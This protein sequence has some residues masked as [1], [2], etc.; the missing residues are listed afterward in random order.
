[1]AHI[2]TMYIL[3]PFLGALMRYNLMSWMFPGRMN[4]LNLKTICV[5]HLIAICKSPPHVGILYEFY[6]LVLFPSIHSYSLYYL[7]AFLSQSVILVAKVGL[8]KEEVQHTKTLQH[9]IVCMLFCNAHKINVLFVLN[10]VEL[11]IALFVRHVWLDEI[12]N[13]RLLW[14]SFV[15][16]QYAVLYSSFCGMC[17][18]VFVYIR[19]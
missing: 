19:A 8:K 16:S 6:S 4:F 5:M 1:M 12:A 3:S 11:L 14:F 18:H 15:S 17:V 7:I 2:Q 13:H 10:W 9:W